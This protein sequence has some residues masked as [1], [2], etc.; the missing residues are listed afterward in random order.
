MPLHPF[1]ILPACRYFT[2]KCLAADNQ[3]IR[4]VTH[5]TDTNRLSPPCYVVCG[6][7]LESSAAIR[8]RAESFRRLRADF[9]EVAAETNYLKRGIR[10][11][12]L[13]YISGIDQMITV[14][15]LDETRGMGDLFL[16]GSLRL[17]I[18]FE[19]FDFRITGGI[20]FPTAKHEPLQ[21]THTVTDFISS[22]IYTINYHYN[23]LNGFGIPIYK[24]S[25]A[26]KVSIS[27]FSLE[28][29][30]VWRDP[31]KEGENIRWSEMLKPDR[32]FTYFSN[33]YQYLLNRT[34]TV[35]ASLGCALSASIS[36]AILNK[37]C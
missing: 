10:G 35:D 14:N 23:N 7:G 13:T 31:L 6:A 33:S 11:E 24:L 28:T 32:T 15:S 2:H 27:N 17:P 20:S 22:G 18:T 36:T 26:A 8:D 9:L 12:S 37:N 34:I 30:F 29:N 21:P 25:G 4:P 16:S 3:S 19:F 1:I 5:T